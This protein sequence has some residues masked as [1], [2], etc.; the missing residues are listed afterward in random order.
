VAAGRTHA[1]GDV[2]RGMNTYDMPTDQTELEALPYT[3]VCPRA[4]AAH[5]G[6][7]ARRGAAAPGRGMLLVYCDRPRGSA[8]ARRG[9]RQTTCP[10]SQHPL[11]I[12]R[13]VITLAGVARWKAAVLLVI[14]DGLAPPPDWRSEPT[15]RARTLRGRG[16]P[17]RSRGGAPA[18]HAHARLARTMRA[19]A[20]RAGQRARPGRRGRRRPGVGVSADG[21][22]GEC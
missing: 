2:T 12:C 1:L 15:A 4:Q 6:A 3:E 7:A 22:E 17:P 14:P 18:W 11:E 5:P 19:R 9:E 8:R 21:S 13:E 20:C 10:V 16:A